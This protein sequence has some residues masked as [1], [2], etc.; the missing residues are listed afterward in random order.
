MRESL[1]LTLVGTG[2]LTGVSVPLLRRARLL[3]RP[4]NRSS[5]DRVVPRG[6]GLP[7]MLVLVPV[8]LVLTGDT[9]STMVLLVAVLLAL[10]GLTD[11][12]SPLPPRT[13]LVAQVVGGV[14][15][16]GTASWVAGVEPWWPAFVVLGSLGFAAYVNAF[17]FMDGINGISALH[18]AVAGVW[19][20]WLGHTEAVP[21]LLVLG[22]ALIGAAVGF[23]PWNAAGAVFLG[24]VG[25][26]GLGAVIAGCTVLA[27]GEGVPGAVAVAPLLVYLA[28]TG[29][30]IV[31]IVRRGDALGTAHRG[32]V[33]QRVVDERGWGHLRTGAWVALASAVCCVVVAL[34]WRQV[35]LPVTAFL[36]C[37]VLVGYLVT[38]LLLGALHGRVVPR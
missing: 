21:A 2:V 10:V 24:D 11:D 28:D 27:W 16:A 34:G 30:V 1:L 4:N 37:S 31:K 15:V 7:V 9:G 36:V 33:Y 20:G 5:H 14:L 19:F 8:G 22:G 18:A 29:W 23:L 3:D 13:R 35:P 25:S 6:G 12:R 38:P 32:H 17:N 26:Y